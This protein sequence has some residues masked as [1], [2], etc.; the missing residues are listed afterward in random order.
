MDSF[1]QGPFLSGAFLLIVL[2]KREETVHHG[3][4]TL[5]SNAHEG[6][7]SL[8]TQRKNR[9]VLR[10]SVINYLLSKESREA[11]SLVKIQ[12]IFPKRNHCRTIDSQ[13]RSIAELRQQSQKE[14]LMKQLHTVLKNMC[15]KV[16]LMFGLGLLHLKLIILCYSQVC[17]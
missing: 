15:G 13:Y 17:K 11:G 8:P 2:E 6:G 7:G 1:F 12:H 16:T 3:S 14:H 4:G 10:A 5:V 9:V